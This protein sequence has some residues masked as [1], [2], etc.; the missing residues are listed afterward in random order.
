MNGVNPSENN[1]KRCPSAIICPSNKCLYI[2][3]RLFEP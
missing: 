1:I 3:H 2:S